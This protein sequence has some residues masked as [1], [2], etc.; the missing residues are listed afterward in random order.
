[1]LDA[2]TQR[3]AQNRPIQG[4][5][6]NI[7]KLA[8]IYLRDAQIKNPI[9]HILMLIH[10]EWVLECSENNA[11]E[12]AALLEECCIKASRVFCKNIDIPAKAV[13]SEK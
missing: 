11:V 12:V 5:A 9:F 8:G 4:T 6:A 3:Q 1:M 7:S 10:D 2:K 13:I